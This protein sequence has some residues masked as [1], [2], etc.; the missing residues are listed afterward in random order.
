[1]PPGEHRRRRAFFVD[2]TLAAGALGIAGLG[3]VGLQL[4]FGIVGGAHMAGGHR[5]GDQIDRHM[6]FF[7]H[8]FGE[9]A[10]AEFQIGI[11]RH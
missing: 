11:G 6:G 1:M 4:F 8:H 9:Q 2:Q 5:V 10:G 7:V 3:K